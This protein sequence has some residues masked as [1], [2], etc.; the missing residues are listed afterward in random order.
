MS[1][2]SNKY[3]SSARQQG[4]TIQQNV[5]NCFYWEMKIIA[6]GIS[7]FACFVW[8]EV[9]PWVHNQKLDISTSN[10]ASRKKLLAHAQLDTPT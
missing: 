2:I 10:K 3:K 4:L 6:C 9:F 8:L 5:I 7:S 1:S